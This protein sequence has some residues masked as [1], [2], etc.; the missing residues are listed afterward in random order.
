MTESEAVA[1]NIRRLGTRERATMTLVAF[2]RNVHYGVLQR[3]GIISMRK[4]CLG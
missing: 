4:K 2:F 3:F 1:N